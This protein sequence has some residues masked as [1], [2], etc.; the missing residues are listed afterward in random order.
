MAENRNVLLNQGTQLMPSEEMLE[1]KKGKNSYTVGVPK[2]SAYQENRVSLAPDSVG[3][4]IA[5]GNRVFVERG[6]GLNSHFTDEE[7]SEAGAEIVENTQEVLQA[8][9]IL[10][11]APLTLSEIDL[12]P[13]RRVVVSALHH[14]MQQSEYFRKLMQKKTTA[15]A[16]EFIKD[17]SGLFPVLKA[18]SEIT[19]YASIQI[20]AENLS[21]N[22]LGKGA[23]L[24]GVPGITPSE[25]VI[26]GAGTVGEYASR[27]ALGL[28]AVVKVF[29]NSIYKLR[30]L[31]NNV[32]SRVFT[33]IIQPKVLQKALKTADVVI[34]A[35]H[36]RHGRTPVVVTE[37]MI[38]EMKPGSVI[39]DVSIDQG[40]C[41]ETSTITN[42]SDPV[43]VKHDVIHYCVPNIP[44]RVPHTAS[45]ALSNFFT[46]L[47]LDI[48]DEGGVD[49]Y[50][51]T[52]YGF[53]QGIYL[54]NGIL[55]NRLIADTYN[56]PYQ[57]LELL[58]A[59]M[60]M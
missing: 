47:L 52:N 32:N 16:F 7:Y 37:D 8:D 44:S 10:K 31:Q 20:A 5:N 11:V 29:D 38:R 17:N 55:T 39:I 48:G 25:V 50:L 41:I 30:L 19:G 23:L 53:R 1:T 3:V 22:D 13:T 36:G 26:L 15:L 14:T 58:I 40:G 43:F 21:R 56:I 2:E 45:Y 60:H 27:A 34:G 4:I 57:E 9:L 46:P 51:K 49:R 54:Y 24:G 33:S 28:G 59:A 6:A 12:L 35:I 42:H 18:M